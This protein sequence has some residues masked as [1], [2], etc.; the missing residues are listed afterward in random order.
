MSANV[1]SLSLLKPEGESPVDQELHTETLIGEPV[2]IRTVTNYYTGRLTA[3]DAQWIELDEA[4]WIADTG[5]WHQA[6]GTGVLNEVEPYPDGPVFVGVGAV[7][8]LCKWGHDL[9]RTA[10]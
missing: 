3:I 2:I 10:K 9:P 4:A 1:K 8:D 5:R 7:V 6:L